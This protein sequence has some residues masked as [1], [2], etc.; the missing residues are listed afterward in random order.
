MRFL[1]KFGVPMDFLLLFFFK[2]NWDGLS[3]DFM[4]MMD[5]F[6]CNGSIIKG[7]NAS[8]VDLLPKKDQN[9]S[10]DRLKTDIPG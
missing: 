10:L 8:F 4:R 3:V 5:D 1:E 7:L 9:Q 6:H 2:E